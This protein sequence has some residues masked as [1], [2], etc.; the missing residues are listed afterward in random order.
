RWSNN[1][2]GLRDNSMKTFKPLVLLLLV[3]VAG[4]LVGVVGT[5]VAVRH[6]IHRVVANPDLIWIRIQ[7]VLAADLR[8]NPDHCAT[9]DRL[10]SESHEQIRTLPAEYQPRSLPVIEKA[11]ADIAAALRPEQRAKFD[12]MLEEKERLWKP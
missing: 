3:F 4:I 11:R 5:R 8:L 10:L 2:V 1:G 9:V 12:K 6:V 7:R